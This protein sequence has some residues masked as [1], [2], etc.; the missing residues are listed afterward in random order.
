MNKIIITDC[1]HENIEMEKEIL[2][3]E[4]VSFELKQCK[5]ENDLIE[6]CQDASVFINQYAPI[7]RKALENLHNLKMVVRYGVGVNTIDVDAATKHD[8]QICNVPDY[9][10]N[11]VAD[12]ALAMMLNFTRKIGMMNKTVH[13]GQWEYQK[14]IPLYRHSEMTVGVIGIG[15]IGSSFARK[16]HALGCK[17]I[18]YDNKY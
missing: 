13:A 4:A 15:R 9:G 8:V 18:G 11:E 1:D 6:Q 2:N 10:V 7:T 16:V 3:K 17:V 12:H 5:T 14:S